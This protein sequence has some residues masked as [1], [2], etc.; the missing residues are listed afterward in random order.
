[1]LNALVSTPRPPQDGVAKFDGTLILVML[2]DRPLRLKNLSR[3]SRQFHKLQ[4]SR[5]SVPKFTL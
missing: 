3:Q 1:M 2:T 4:I 5:L